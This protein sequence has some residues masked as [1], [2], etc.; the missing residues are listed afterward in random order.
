MYSIDQLLYLA[1]IVIALLFLAN[2]VR[3]FWNNNASISF[4]L[5]ILTAASSL[6]VA[7]FW[8]SFFGLIMKWIVIVIWSIISILFIVQMIRGKF[9]IYPFENKQEIL[10]LGIALGAAIIYLIPIV[11]YNRLYF[12]GDIFAYVSEADFL[13]EYAYLT[14]PNFDAFSPWLYEPYIYWE[15]GFRIGAQM[16]LSFWATIFRRE[17]SIELFAPCVAVGI[18]LITVAVCSFGESFSEK[19][20]DKTVN[21]MALFSALNSTI[22]FWSATMGLL[23]QI[24]GFVFS[25]AVISLFINGG[26]YEKSISLHLVFGIVATALILSYNEL[27]PFTVLGLFIYFCWEW[28][29]NKSDRRTM[30][31]YLLLDTFATLAFCCIYVPNVVKAILRQMVDVVGYDIKYGIFEYIGYFFS[32]T[33]VGGSEKAGQTIFCIVLTMIVIAFLINGVISSIRE[34]S[35]IV[36][37]SVSIMLPYVI[38]AIYFLLFTRNPWNE[39]ERGNTWSVYKIVQYC[40]VI[41]IPY[42]ILF[43]VKGSKKWKKVFTCVGII[44]C[45]VNT[46]W[47]LEFQ[48]WVTSYAC[49]LTGNEKNPK[50]EYY[51]LREKYRGCEEKIWL[52]GVP[53][54]HQ[55]A[56]SYF[57]KDSQV[58]TIFSKPGAE[59]NGDGIILT[60]DPTTEEAANLTQTD[61]YFNYSESLYDAEAS[62]EESWKWAS[63]DTK[64]LITP[65]ELGTYS[66]GFRLQAFD[67]TEEVVVSMNGNVVYEGLISSTEYTDVSFEMS[68]SDYT[69]SEIN[70]EYR[71]DAKPGLN[72]DDRLF[73]YRIIDFSIEPKTA[74]SVSTSQNDDFLI[75]YGDTFYKEEASAEENWRWASGNAKCLVMPAKTGKYL[76]QFQMQALEEGEVTIL[77]NEDVVYEGMISS[78]E[79]TNVAFEMSWDE[80]TGQEINIIYKGDGKSNVNGDARMLAY[81]VINFEI[82][83]QTNF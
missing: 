42:T 12:Y 70:I 43:I 50:E 19:L 29:K 66:V 68:W 18:F 75:E 54:A 34:K 17:L 41:M 16:F 52:N 83:P 8:L 9:K 26:K 53:N 49:T 3:S 76:V 35:S 77:A 64:I 2:L 33:Y 80:L 72:G 24:F 22:I 20:N 74:D 61:F 23:P 10:R 28:F 60:Y 31:K 4:S 62:V 1:I 27:L 47:A 63:G 58:N 46:I 56:I 25:I 7:V 69:R 14:E 65:T 37:E 73:A 11:Y 71:G 6:I 39:A 51:K 78:K 79:Y 45:C 21:I 5:S 44:W 57:L 13:K 67:D 59:Y 48:T 82:D 81:R 36:K 15:N 38:M 32:T 55:L 30:I 40:T